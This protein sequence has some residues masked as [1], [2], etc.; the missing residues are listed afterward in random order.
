VGLLKIT[1]DV[2]EWIELLRIGFKSGQLWT[3]QRNCRLYERR[4]TSFSAERS[5]DSEVLSSVL[6]ITSFYKE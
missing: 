1:G 6:S 4:R 3:G 5:S 2:E